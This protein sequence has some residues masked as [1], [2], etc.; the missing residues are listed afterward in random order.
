MSKPSLDTDGRIRY[1]LC[2]LNLYF[3]FLR[4]KLCRLATILIFE[5]SAIKILSA[6]LRPFNLV[7]LGFQSLF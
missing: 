4:I 5:I 6:G 2:P 3:C 1:N 7:N